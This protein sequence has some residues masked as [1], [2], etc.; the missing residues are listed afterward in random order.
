MTRLAPLKLVPQAKL[1][2]RLSPVWHSAT[3]IELRASDDHWEKVAVPHDSIAKTWYDSINLLH[4]RVFGPSV[5]DFLTAIDEF[6][7][8]AK[9]KQRVVRP[10]A[11]ADFVTDGPARMVSL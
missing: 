4:M 9:P 3:E 11:A 2:V 7:L 1:F 6:S 8:V 5:D 10:V